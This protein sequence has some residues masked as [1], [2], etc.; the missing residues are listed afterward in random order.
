MNNI[1][2]RINEVIN[3]A[4]SLS[5]WEQEVMLRRISQIIDGGDNPM[6]EIVEVVSGYD[7][8]SCWEQEGM[9]RRIADIMVAH[10]RGAINNC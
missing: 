1:I 9:L 6:D 5:C 3:N 8:L 2:S 4:D 7:S 10:W